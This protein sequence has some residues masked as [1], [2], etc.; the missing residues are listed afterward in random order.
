MPED[1]KQNYSDADRAAIERIRRKMMRLMMIALIIT[2]ALIAAVMA[3]LIYK[4]TR[5]SKAAAESAAI[6]TP[7]PASGGIEATLPLPAGARILSHSLSG[8]F[9]S[10]LVQLP[11]GSSELLVYDY[12]AQTPVAQLRM[13]VEV[14]R[15]Q[16]MQ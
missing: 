12:Q 5:S 3:A 13:P 16:E 14:N 1:Q 9:V 6:T 8:K 7:L 15:P 4:T 10:L 11:D 2:I